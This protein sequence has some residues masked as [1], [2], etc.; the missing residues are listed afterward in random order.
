LGTVGGFFAASVQET[1]GKRAKA[2]VF[3]TVASSEKNLQSR[4]PNIY[5]M[6]IT[7]W[8]ATPNVE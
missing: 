4:K 6:L 5:A 1:E 3:L 2:T 7:D 8:R